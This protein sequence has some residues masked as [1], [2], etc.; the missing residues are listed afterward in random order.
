MGNRPNHT[1]IAQN[2]IAHLKQSAQAEQQ[3]LIAERDALQ[4]K[5]ADLTP[6]TAEVYKPTVDHMTAELATQFRSNANFSIE[7]IDDTRAMVR[8]DALPNSHNTD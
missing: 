3:R 2:A 1:H 5:C 4:R 7:M 8:K 6:M